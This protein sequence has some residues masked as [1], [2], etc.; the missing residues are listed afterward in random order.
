MVTGPGILFSRLRLALYKNRKIHAQILIVFH[1]LCLR[2]SWS[3]SSSTFCVTAKR[4]DFGLF[5]RFFGSAV[6]SGGQLASFS[7]HSGPCH[8]SAQLWEISTA[9]CEVSWVFLSSH[10]SPL[11]PLLL[12]YLVNSVSNKLFVDLSIT[13]P[14]DN[15]CTIQPFYHSPHWK[16]FNCFLDVMD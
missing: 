1:Q 13:N 10:V 11:D 6:I 16:S 4:G 9:T 12:L 8:Q 3:S 2:R 7:N 5:S 14:A 15:D